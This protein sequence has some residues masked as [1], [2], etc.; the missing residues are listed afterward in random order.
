MHDSFMRPS[1]LTDVIAQHTVGQ[2]G[3]ADVVILSLKHD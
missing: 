2:R 3:T 1:A